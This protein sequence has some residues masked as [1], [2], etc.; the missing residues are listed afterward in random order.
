MRSEEFTGVGVMQPGN[1]ELKFAIRCSLF[2][3]LLAAPY[4]V[5]VLLLW[6]F[7]QKEQYSYAKPLG[8]S[9]LQEV[10]WPFVISC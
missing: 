8:P 7:N 9:T 3:Q 5:M 4:E 6:G 1:R 2:W 10:L